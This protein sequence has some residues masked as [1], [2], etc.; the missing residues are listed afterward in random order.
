MEINALSLLEL[1]R[2]IKEVIKAHTEKKYW[3]VAEISEMK[4]NYSGHCYLELIQKDTSTD[5]IVARSRATIWAPNFRMIKPYFETTTGRPLTE[6]LSILVKVAVEFHEVF[7]LS[8]N[9]TDIEPTYTVG[10]LAIRK[11]KIIERLTEEGVIGM[12]KELELPRPC[13]KIAIISSVSAAGCEDFIDQLTNNP[14]GFKFYIKLFPAVMQ[15]AEAEQSIISALERIYAYESFFDCVVIIRGGGSQADLSCFDS[16]WVAYH[17]SQFPLPVLTGIGH[18]QDDSVVDMVAHTRLKT[19]TAVAAFLVEEMTQLLAELGELENT[20]VDTSQEYLLRVRNKLIL[21]S[22]NFQFAVNN[23]IRAA[24]NYLTMAMHTM[25]TNTHRQIHR[26]ELS[27]DR[28]FWALCFNSRSKAENARALLNTTSGLMKRLANHLTAS[29]HQLVDS[30][31]TQLQALDPLKV[32][33]RGYSITSSHGK[34]IKD[35][36]LVNE[37][38][39]LETRLHKGKLLLTVKKKM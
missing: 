3:V 15:G 22:R 38:D 17:I 19:P 2:S 29:Q 27:L 1:N 14:A 9:I 10:E 16:Y 24:D 21:L 35:T 8:L 37:G 18:E 13:Q 5:Q 25:V 39:D 32:L 36:A 28:T 20:L 34:I 4:V 23:S 30:L 12:N 31:N 11:Q 6:G 26:T 7:G 33:S